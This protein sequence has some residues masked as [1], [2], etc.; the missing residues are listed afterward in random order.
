MN[1]ESRP[2]PS[3]TQRERRQKRLKAVEM[4]AIAYM[5]RQGLRYRRDGP[6][7]GMTF[8]LPVVV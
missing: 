3:T 4:M 8:V 1:G 6:E 5:T 7:R 2:D